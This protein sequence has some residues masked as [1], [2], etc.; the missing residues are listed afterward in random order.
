MDTTLN[1]SISFNTAH[2]VTFESTDLSIA[3]IDL[4]DYALTFHTNHGRPNSERQISFAL[5][6]H[7]TS[8]R[9]PLQQGSVFSSAGYTELTYDGAQSRR[10]EYSI[11]SG[12]LEINVTGAGTPIRTYEV[13][14]FVLAVKSGIGNAT[15]ELKGS[16]TFYV[17][18]MN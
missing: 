17:E 12:V 2:R 13:K 10:N 18:E 4:P 6:N 16:F 11:I 7:I 1:G 15:R 3:S 9:Y 5:L 14:E 8:G